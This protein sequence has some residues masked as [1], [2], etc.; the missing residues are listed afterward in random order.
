ME[1]TT[2]KEKAPKEPVKIQFTQ[3]ETLLRSIIDKNLDD[4]NQAPSEFAKIILTRKEEA[5]KKAGIVVSETMQAAMLKDAKKEA[6]SICS[7]LGIK[8]VRI[9]QVLK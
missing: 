3:D 5:M 2:K 9:G 4:V 8:T 6:R 1:T 7:S